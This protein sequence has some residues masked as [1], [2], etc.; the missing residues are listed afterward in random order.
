MTRYFKRRRA[1]GKE[2]A[3]AMAA[4]IGTGLV[5][6]YFVRILLSREPIEMPS[7]DARGDPDART[8]RING[9]RATD[10]ASGTTRSSHR[11]EAG[12]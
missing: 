11:E 7:R 4:A 2:N 6:F 5:V 1:G 9:T 10:R 3:G 8:G 12:N